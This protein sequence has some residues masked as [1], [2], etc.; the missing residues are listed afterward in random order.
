MEFRFPLLF[1]E[2]ARCRCYSMKRARSSQ[3]SKPL[4]TAQKSRLAIITLVQPVYRSTSEGHLLSQANETESS[5]SART[6]WRTLSPPAGG[7]KATH[8]EFAAPFTA[9]MVWSSQE[10]EKSDVDE[11]ESSAALSSSAIWMDSSCNTS[12]TEGGWGESRPRASAGRKEAGFNGKAD[13]V[14]AVAVISASKP[15]PTLVHEERRAARDGTSP[16]SDA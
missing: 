5:D 14:V 9:A 2:D 8:V 16:E 3:G 12:P 1:L 4:Q 13:A 6:V 11:S 7:L 10:Q 15:T